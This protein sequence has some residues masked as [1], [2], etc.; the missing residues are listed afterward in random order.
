MPGKT[1]LACQLIK[2]HGDHGKRGTLA[3]DAGER[4]VN[5]RSR[6]FYRLLL[7]S[8]F[9]GAL[10]A[11][12][13]L[14]FFL[15]MTVGIQFIWE[16]LPRWSVLSSGTDSAVSIIIVC[17]VGG[18][19]VGLITRYFRSKPLLLAEELGDFVEDGRLD[20]RSGAV[21]LLRGLVGL[22]FGGSIGPE[23][24]LTGATGGMGT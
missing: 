9:V 1:D 2:A 11:L 19:L 14:A 6:P 22:L 17:A 13:T 21:G 5:I 15:A 16:V 18:L 4:E 12:L 7:L 10:G 23:G 3:D 20:P 8:G 24:P